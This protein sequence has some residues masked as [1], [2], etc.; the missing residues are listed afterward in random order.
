M[1]PTPD[2]FDQII[3]RRLF[4]IPQGSIPTPDKF[5]QIITTE[6]KTPLFR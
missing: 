4:E 3:T 6:R 1:I 2:K 5:D